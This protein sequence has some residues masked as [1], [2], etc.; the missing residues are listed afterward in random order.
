MQQIHA[1]NFYLICIFQSKESFI[2]KSSTKLACFPSLIIAFSNQDPFVQICLIVLQWIW[3]WGLRR[4]HMSLSASIFYTY[5]E[6]YIQL[7]SETS[8]TNTH[9]HSFHPQIFSSDLRIFPINWSKTAHTKILNFTY[10][11]E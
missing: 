5:M 9:T 10:Q 6:R 4:V 2:G 1:E 7:I 11:H 3:Q 8:I